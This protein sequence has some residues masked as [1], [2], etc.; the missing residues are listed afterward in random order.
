MVS[1]ERSILFE[2]CAR[3]LDRSLAVG[4]HRL[5]LIGAGDW[6]D[7]MNRVGVDGKGESIWLGWFLCASLSA[8]TQL[9][10]GR[11]EQARTGAWLQ[12]AAAL[13]ESMGRDGWDG[14]WYRRGYFDDGTPLGSA[15]S[16]ECRIDSIAQ[17]WAVISGASDK[18]RAV[19]A[20]AALEEYL[21]RRDDGLLLLFSP[22]FDRTSLDPG[23]IK[24]YP[25][26]IREN[27]GQY[28]HGA[29]WSVLAFA[30]LGDGDK[31]GELFSLLNP[32]N[33]W[34]TRA[35]IYRYKVEPY[36]TCGDV[37]AEPAHIGR[38]G[39]TWYTGSAG[40][41]Y[42]VGLEWILGF[43][44]RGATRR[45]CSTRACRRRGETS[46]STFAITP[47][48]MTS[49]SR[50]HRESA[51]VSRASSSTAKR[52]RETWDRSCWRTTVGLT[53]CV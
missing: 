34:S 41:M 18:N 22:P 10:D 23:Y 44:L 32:I 12:H 48:A 3:A 31:A 49:R 24:G 45:C 20:M 52:Y 35:A 43:R 7:G 13:R 5:P 8:F 1:E 50:I 30:M 4:G 46:K 11:G 37:Y 53:G 47:R 19:T 25:P 38:G 6:N 36:V 26:G 15:A 9:A 39:W 40:W 29:L 27:G 21:V 51:M 42:R 17:S 33:H 16:S 2:H 28:T 14:D